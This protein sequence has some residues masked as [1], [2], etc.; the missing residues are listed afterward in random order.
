[1]ERP[2]DVWD[3]KVLFALSY[4]RLL[5]TGSSCCPCPSLGSSA[6]IHRML[7][8]GHYAHCSYAELVMLFFIML[9]VLIL[10]FQVRSCLSTIP[11][12]PQ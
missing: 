1:M 12:V 4:S 7:L 11:V 9:N 6:P 3:Q 2:W 8:T 10:I 5:C